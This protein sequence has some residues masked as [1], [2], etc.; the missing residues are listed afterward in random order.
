MSLGDGLLIYLKIKE[1]LTH[2]TESIFWTE[3][4]FRFQFLSNTASVSF[5]NSVIIIF[6]F[7][8]IS[9]L[10]LNTEIDNTYSYISTIIV[11]V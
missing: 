2:K 9:V 6:F 8:H 7:G 10:R 3:I 1:K 11:L 4:L 5:K